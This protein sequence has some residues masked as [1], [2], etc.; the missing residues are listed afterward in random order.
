VDDAG[1]V[2]SLEPLGHL[3]ADVE[4]LVH[5]QRPRLDH[6]GQGRPGDQL[7]NEEVD[8]VDVLEAVDGGHVRVVQRGEELGL[9]LEAGQPLR[10]AGELHGE[11]L[12]GHLAPQLRILGRPDDAHPPLA[13]LLDEAVMGQNGSTLEL[14][15]GAGSWAVRSRGR[16]NTTR[17]PSAA[18]AGA[19]VR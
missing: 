11:D 14:H 16:E 7:E 19:M 8:I 17:S 10:V 2:G 1:L 18:P 3:A 12:D 15:A 6:P 4:R 9:P 5:G 13:D